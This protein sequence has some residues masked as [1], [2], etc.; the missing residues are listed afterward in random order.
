MKHNR[1][2]KLITDLTVRQKVYGYLDIDRV[3]N[4]HIESL[5]ND[6][7]KDIASFKEFKEF[8][9]YGADRAYEQ[10]KRNKKIK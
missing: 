9:L 2:I 4:K 1:I 7:V 5:I 8:V 6:N 3:I 10:A